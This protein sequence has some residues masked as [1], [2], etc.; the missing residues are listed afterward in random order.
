MSHVAIQSYACKSVSVL[1]SPW[2]SVFLVPYLRRIPTTSHNRQQNPAST[3]QIK[4][5]LMIIVMMSGSSD[6]APAPDDAHNHTAELLGVVCCPLHSVDRQGW[7]EMCFHL[8]DCKAAW[9]SAF[10]L[11]LF[12]VP[13]AVC[14][15]THG[16]SFYTSLVPQGGSNIQRSRMMSSDSAESQ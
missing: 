15:D 16:G 9:Q 13:S 6:P 10:P 11:S 7:M 8:R 2:R 5:T 3:A 14:D 12:L 4:A 1:Q